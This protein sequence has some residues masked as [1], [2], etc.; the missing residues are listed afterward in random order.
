MGLTAGVNGL[1]DRNP[2]QPGD[3]GT[4]SCQPTQTTV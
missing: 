1:R 3:A 2:D 4:S